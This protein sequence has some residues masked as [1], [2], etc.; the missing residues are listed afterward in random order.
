MT[1]YSNIYARFMRK[2][3]DYNLAELVQ[4]T[5]EE[6]IKGYLISSIAK[7]NN[8]EQDL[9]NRDDEVDTFNIT[10]TEKEEEIL[11]INMVVEWLNPKILTDENIKLLITNKNWQTYSPGNLLK[12][13]QNVR[14]TFK[15][16][17]NNLINAYISTV[18]RIRVLRWKLDIIIWI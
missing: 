10:L 3:T 14:K 4:E 2:I 16:E 5:A 7:Y 15:S 9:N 8:C 12:E 11:S 13:L 18:E 6:I 17:V 1:P